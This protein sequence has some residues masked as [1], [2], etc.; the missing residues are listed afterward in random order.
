MAPSAEL[1]ARGAPQ[2][3]QNLLPAST[4]AP[5]L[6]QTAPNVAP[7][8]R[9]NRARS[10][11]SAWHLGHFMLRDLQLGEPTRLLRGT[12]EPTLA[13]GSPGQESG[14]GWVD[15]DFRGVRWRSLW[16]PLSL[17]IWDRI[18]PRRSARAE[19]AWRRRE[20]EHPAGRGDGT[21]G[22]RRRGTAT[23]A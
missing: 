16:T 17:L 9:Q 18:I 13:G 5:Q 14:L 7:H 20:S 11:F 1:A 12:S 21:Q 3:S 19:G 10:R 4:S 2:P 8:S 22:E 23:R 15:P 6:E